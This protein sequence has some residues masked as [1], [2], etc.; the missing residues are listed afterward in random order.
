MTPDEDDFRLIQQTIG[1]ALRRAM[2]G[3]EETQLPQEIVMLLNKLASDE[4]SR[5]L[6]GE[7]DRDRGTP[8][9]RDYLE[10][11][12]DLRTRAIACEV[13]QIERAR[14]GPRMSG[15]LRGEGACKEQMI[16]QTHIKLWTKKQRV[17]CKSVRRQII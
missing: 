3:E 13:D 15:H 7:D 16:G 10:F 6:A 8:S 17:S 11:S 2:E 14:I 5:Q 12:A 1:H 9:G 4:I